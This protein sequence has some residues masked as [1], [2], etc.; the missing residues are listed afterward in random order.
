MQ[1][2]NKQQQATAPG[3]KTLKHGHV[4][5]S[6]FDV[7]DAVKRV[8]DAVQGVITIEAR[9]QGFATDEAKVAELDAMAKFK[10]AHAELASIL[11]AFAAERGA[12]R[13]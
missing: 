11:E 6:K 1:T 13:A 4:D 12:V 8:S 5:V 9:H 10:T 2:G 7:L 3:T